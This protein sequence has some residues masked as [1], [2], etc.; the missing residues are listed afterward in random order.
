MSLLRKSRAP[1]ALLIAVSCL[2]GCDSGVTSA[3][4]FP[5]SDFVPSA[6]ALEASNHFSGRLSVSSD[7][8]RS[9][10]SLLKDELSLAGSEGIDTLPVL[11]L[12]LEQVG[13]R[14]EPVG[15]AFQHERHPWWQYIV[16]PGKVWD[17]PGDDGYSRAALPFALKERNADCIHNGLFGFSYRGDGTVSDIKFQ[18]THQTCKY[19]QFEWHGFL[20]AEYRPADLEL[21]RRKA[22]QPIPQRPITKLADDYPG[23]TPAN[24]GSAAE[25]DP[26]TMTTWGLV[27]DGVHYTGS[28]NT[29]LGE[30]PYCDAMA[31]PSYSTAKSF[32]AGL[33]ARG[34]I[35]VRID[36]DSASEAERFAMGERI[37]AVRQGPAGA[38]WLLED[39][40]GGRLLKLTPGES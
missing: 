11:E 25:I 9:R 13:E 40:G 17:E 39:G 37:R 20:K 35:R 33:S 24:F 5:V 7:M 4:P 31:L 36:G 2:Q 19:L 28:C 16:L 8:G 6:D 30:Y 14:L 1:T 22:A 18:I 23:A 3:G 26:E 34:L 27:I 15:P 29:P 10:F 12:G 38:I 32:I 21:P